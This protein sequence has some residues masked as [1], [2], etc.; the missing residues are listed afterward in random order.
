[1]KHVK[2]LMIC[3]ARLH[4]FCIDRRLA[5]VDHCDGRHHAGPPLLFTLHNVT[6]DAHQQHVQELAS[7][8]EFDDAEL[9]YDNPYSAD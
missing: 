1:M 9:I 6:F 7:E 4:N 5:E 3:I 2:H 8:I